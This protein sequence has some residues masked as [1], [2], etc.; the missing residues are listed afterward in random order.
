METARRLALLTAALPAVASAATVAAPRLRHSQV[1][2]ASVDDVHHQDPIK[3]PKLASYP[4]AKP[5]N[6][7]DTQETKYVDGKRVKVEFAAGEKI[8][9][10]CEKGFTTDGAKDGGSE[11]EVECS[12]QGY[13][14][15][16]GVCLKASKCGAAPEIANARPTGQKK[17]DSLEYGCNEGYSLDGEQVVAGGM[18]KN[19]LFMMKCVEFSGDFEKFEG[20]CK[21]YQFVS[22]TETARMYNQVFEALFTVSCK[23]TL[24]KAFGEGKGP[25]VDGA[26]GKITDSGLKGECD[27]LVSKIKSDFESEKAAREEHDKGAKKDWFE[28]KDPERPGITDEASEFCTSL[29]KI[30]EHKPAAA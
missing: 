16:G 5:K 7:A 4:N 21:P 29:W 25:G 12:E 14:K 15:P 13:Y 3:C 23:G 1:V 2:L 20:E 9:F 10:E 8:P 28:E 22:A 11:F 19:R 18:G 17:G 26:C 27:G 24:K 30:L 6:F